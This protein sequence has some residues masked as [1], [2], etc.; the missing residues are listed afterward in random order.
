MGIWFRDAAEIWLITSSSC[1]RQ[2]PTS[3]VHVGRRSAATGVWRKTASELKIAHGRRNCGDVGRRRLGCRPIVG[4]LNKYSKALRPTCRF[5]TSPPTKCRCWCLPIAKITSN[6]SRG[7]PAGRASI[8]P[9]TSPGFTMHGV[10]ASSWI[11]HKARCDRYSARVRAWMLTVRYDLPNTGE[12]IQEGLASYYQLKATPQP[13]FN[14]IVRHSLTK[15]AAFLPLETLCNGQG[16]PLNR[17]WQAVTVCD[18]LLNDDKY[19]G[20][21]PDLFARLH[22]VDSTD[23]G[24]HLEPVYGVTWE[25]FLNNWK[26]FCTKRY[27]KS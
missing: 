5:S 22:E 8:A 24:P 1:S 3:A 17:Y 25:E 9:P 2:P 27:P 4:A 12:W 26:Y 18:M 7:W 11:R 6:S 10:S 14:D 16:I 19:K 23:L 15:P 21:T 20:K 13:N